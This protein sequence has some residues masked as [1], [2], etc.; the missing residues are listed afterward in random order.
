M[1]IEKKTKL[2]PRFSLAFPFLLTLLVALLVTLVTI[3][4]WEVFGAPLFVFVFGISVISALSFI[5][6]D[7]GDRRFLFLVVGLGFLLRVGA[8]LI[9]DGVLNAP[10]GIKDELQ[11]DRIGWAVAQAWRQGQSFPLTLEVVY[12]AHHTFYYLT[13]CVYFVI[14]HSPFAMK[15]F[16][17]LISALTIYYGFQLAKHLFSRRTA[18]ITAWLICVYTGFYLSTI[19]ILKDALVAF[20]SMAFLWHLTQWQESGFRRRYLLVMGLIWVVFV[21]LRWYAA[22]ILALLAARTFFVAKVHSRRIKRLVYGMA[23]LGGI[24]TFLWR[25]DELLTRLGLPTLFQFGEVSTLGSALGTVFIFSPS[26]KTVF[27]LLMANP[28]PFLA[29]LILGPLTTLLAP[30][31]WV[32]PGMLPDAVWNAYYVSYPG[33]WVWYGVLPFAA[34]GLAEVIKRW[35]QQTTVRPVFLFGL[36]L[37]L[38]FGTLIPREVR[39]RDMVMPIGL[40]LASVGIVYGWRYRQLAILF[41]A[42]LFL[43]AVFKIQ[44]IEMF[45]RI[46]LLSVPFWLWGLRDWYWPKV[47]KWLRHLGRLGV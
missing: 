37:F 2:H 21:N 7:T 26:L 27:H 28:V 8:A 6:A 20:L 41:W 32:F 3:Y 25:G 16:N 46:V 33:M 11:Y 30:Y 15:I 39:H 38:V 35:R 12:D 19:L 5:G 29:A 47:S 10:F 1:V 34:F 40:M 44:Q 36:T 4:P 42:P 14:G 43:G 45:I 31:A 18:V 17:S 24:A 13:G 9:Y 22:D 23:V